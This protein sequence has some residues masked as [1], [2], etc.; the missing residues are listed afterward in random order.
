MAY[1]LQ[2]ARKLVIKAGL[3]LLSSGLIARTWG[4]ISARISDTQFVITPSGLAYEDLTPEK[5]VI[6]NI[7]NCSYQGR[8]KP[9]SEKWIHADAY[10]LRPDVNFV[11]HTHQNYASALSILG[12]TISEIP[13]EGNLRSILGPEIPTAGYGLN[14]SQELSRNVIRAIEDHPSSAA[15]LMSNHGAECMGVDYADAFAIAHALEDVAKSRYRRMLQE[16]DLLSILPTKEEMD[17][18]DLCGSD[19]SGYY[20]VI[21]PCPYSEAAAVFSSAPFT[22]AASRLPISELFPYIDDQAQMIGTS[23][24]VIPQDADDQM[25]QD[26]LQGRNAVL[27]RGKGAICTGDSPEDVDAAVM[28]LEKGCRAALLAMAAGDAGKIFPLLPEHAAADRSSYV[29]S[30][31]KLKST[32]HES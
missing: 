1:E 31:S 19:L 10:R 24:R 8:L 28:V 13:M 32:G 20:Q 14:G 25:I 7:S 3:E 18:V 11:I 6:T 2:E 21:H 17:A 9:S 30:Y 5:I 26:A 4:N 15:L 29:N 12:E 22:A 27:I 16:S 23:L